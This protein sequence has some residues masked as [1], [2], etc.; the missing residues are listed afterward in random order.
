MLR[1]SSNEPQGRAGLGVLH[2]ESALEAPFELGASCL[3]SSSPKL[4]Q[5]RVLAQPGIGIRAHLTSPLATQRADQA[6]R[7]LPGHLGK[8]SPEALK[9]IARL[10]H[11]LEARRAHVVP[12]ERPPGLC[13]GAL[14]STRM[15]HVHL[16]DGMLEGALVHEQLALKPQG[17]PSAQEPPTAGAIAHGEHAGAQR[18]LRLAGPALVSKD[19]HISGRCCHAADHLP[20]ARGQRQ[21]NSVRVEP[22]D[23]LRMGQIALEEGKLHPLRGEWD[24]TRQP[25]GNGANEKGKAME[26]SIALP[27]VSEDSAALLGV[28]RPPAR[29]LA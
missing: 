14:T 16:K 9:L 6:W 18:F 13:S 1:L 3:L 8:G 15:P 11:W 23:P 22:Q 12:D 24:W 25:F 19:N 10:I 20:R 27:V 26:S 4:H 21:E 5:A 17:P 2:G 7:G 29:I 28:Q